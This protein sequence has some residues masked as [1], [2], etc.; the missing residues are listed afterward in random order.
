MARRLVLA[1][2]VIAVTVATVGIGVAQAQQTDPQA[3]PASQDQPPASGPG[4]GGPG[5]EAQGGTT[6]QAVTQTATNQQQIVGQPTCGPWQRAWYVS[7]GGY[8]YF[9]WWRWC[10]NPSLG[11][12]YAYYIDWAGWN[13]YGP[14][15]PGLSPGWYYNGA[16]P[17]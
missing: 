2:I 3:Q 6:S 1:L 14:A 5:P 7:R 8:W 10:Y 11:P 4:T 15:P 13:W 17:Y 12:Q 9:F 16:P